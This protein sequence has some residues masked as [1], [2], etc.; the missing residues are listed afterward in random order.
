MR[1]DGSGLNADVVP[2]SS[3]ES[4]GDGKA[5]EGA[6]GGFLPTQCPTLK[7]CRWFHAK[8]AAPVGIARAAPRRAAIRCVFL[9]EKKFCTS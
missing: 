4:Y 8:A 3:A 9:L 2:P 1:R 6:I 7:F 5:H